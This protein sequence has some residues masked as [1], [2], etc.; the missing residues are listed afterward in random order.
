MTNTKKFWVDAMNELSDEK[1]SAKSFK[2]V[3]A[4]SLAFETMAAEMGV[5]WD[6][7]D[8]AISF[9]DPEQQP[10]E[11]AEQPAED[12]EQP[13]HSDPEPAQQA[14]GAEEPAEEPRP[15]G[16]AP[17]HLGSATITV[18]AESN[19]KRP[20]TNAHAIFALYQTGMTVA[21]FLRAGGR[22]VDL[23]WDEAHGFISVA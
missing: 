23:R 3:G 4:A 5:S 10:A 11:D 8:G 9:V 7:V 15:A 6:I 21:E 16:R 1:I 2:N 17:T 14:E 20:G 22:R 18:V 12:A 19:P 13:Q